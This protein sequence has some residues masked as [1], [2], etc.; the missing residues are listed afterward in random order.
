MEPGTIQVMEP[1]LVRIV[2]NNKNT[3]YQVKWDGVRML[4][5][6]REGQV[7]LQNRQGRLKTSAFPELKCL[8]GLPF[9]H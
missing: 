2:P 3:T 9:S 8:C 6:I 5:F 7:I 1:V 4:A